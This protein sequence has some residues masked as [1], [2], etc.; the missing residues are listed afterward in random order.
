MNTND[1][2]Q[3]V[4]SDLKEIVYGSLGAASA[5]FMSQEK[6]GTEIVMPSKEL[7]EIGDNIIEQFSTLFLEH[8]KLIREGE[9]ER[10]IKLVQNNRDAYMLPTTESRFIRDVHLTPDSEKGEEYCKEHKDCHGHADKNNCFWP[11]C[12]RIDCH[13]KSEEKDSKQL[14]D[15]KEL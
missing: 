1:F 11:P 9:R 5:L 6:K 3:K 7:K 2:I 12:V 15:N 4:D 14:A 13:L 10:V 8:E